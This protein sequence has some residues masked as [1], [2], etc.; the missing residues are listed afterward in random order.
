MKKKS[1]WWVILAILIIGI[2]VGYV[3]TGVI[4]NL[5]D[6]ESSV[7]NGDSLT[8]QEVDTTDSISSEI[9]STAVQNQEEQETEA[10][11]VVE[12]ET[13]DNTAAKKQGQAVDCF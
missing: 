11:E 12:D 3:A 6:K 5:A 4:R 10:K 2:P 9:D 8:I 1:N 13:T 7:A